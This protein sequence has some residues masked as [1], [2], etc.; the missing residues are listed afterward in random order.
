MKLG[1]I[2]DASDWTQV[3]SVR[4]KRPIHYTLAPVHCAFF[5]LGSTQDGQGCLLPQ[6][7]KGHHSAL[8][9]RAPRD[10]MHSSPQNYLPGLDAAFDRS[11]D[12]H[13]PVESTLGNPLHNLLAW[14][15]QTSQKIHWVS[16]L[17]EEKWAAFVEFRW[18]F[19]SFCLKSELSQEES[20]TL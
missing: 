15:L 5:K 18:A 6:L 13:N 4:G 17:W 16:R 8:E 7:L 2:W 1:A 9:P 14:A 20:G 3:S 10:C 19:C 12:E 11:W